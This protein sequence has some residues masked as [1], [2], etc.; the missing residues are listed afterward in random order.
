ML[1][2]SYTITATSVSSNVTCG[3][4]PIAII[5][6]IIVA[7][8]MAAFAVFTG[9][10]R[11]RSGMP[12]VGSC[13]AAISAACHPVPGLEKMV[14]ADAPLQWGV[15]GVSAEGLAHCGFSSCQVEPPEDNVLYA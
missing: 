5:F 9:C 7:V 10:K 12:V 1:S 4:S 8:L 3:Y 14:E 2:D 13:S 6:V 15:M 11:F